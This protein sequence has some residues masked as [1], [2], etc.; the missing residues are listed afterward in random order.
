MRYADERC[1]ADVSLRAM[2]PDELAPRV[3]SRYQASYRF[4][5]DVA[6]GVEIASEVDLDGIG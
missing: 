4:A 5:V 6:G 1:W 3:I 2:R